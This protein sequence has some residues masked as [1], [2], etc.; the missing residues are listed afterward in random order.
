MGI[1]RIHVPVWSTE[2]VRSRGVLGTK[3]ELVL[4]SLSMR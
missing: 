4:C 2:S 3:L 1:L